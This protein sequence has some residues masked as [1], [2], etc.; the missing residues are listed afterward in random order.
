[1]TCEFCGPPAGDVIWSNATCRV[2][3]VDDMRFPGFSRV[4]LTR[5]ATEMADLD[6]TERAALMRVVFALE[7]AVRDVCKPDK[8]NLA[9]LG[10]VTAHVHWHVIPRW[11]DDSHFPDPI[12]GPPRRAGKVRTF[13]AADREALRTAVA[14]HLRTM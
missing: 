5:H 11:R 14:A 6:A 2:V 1:M 13:S 9:S 12:W 3:V 7:R 10:N 8:L 4:I